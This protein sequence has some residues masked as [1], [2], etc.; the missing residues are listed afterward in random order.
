MASEVDHGVWIGSSMVVDVRD[1]IFGQQSTRCIWGNEKRE[2]H[3]RLVIFICM[4]SL[5]SHN[6][7]LLT[8]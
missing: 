1:I 8:K 5:N 7:S 3:A 2:Y 4:V 6:N